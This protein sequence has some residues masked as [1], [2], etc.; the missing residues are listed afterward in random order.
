MIS[1]VHSV[2]FVPA[3]ASCCQLLNLT[4]AVEELALCCLI[5]CSSTALTLLF[6]TIVDSCYDIGFNTPIPIP[7][8]LIMT[9]SFGGENKIEN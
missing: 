2:C 6:S 9:K 7:Q 1:T 8:E 5:A 3:H 4:V